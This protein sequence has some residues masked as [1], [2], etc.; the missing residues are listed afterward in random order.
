MLFIILARLKRTGRFITLFGR[1][2]GCI[3]ALGR[4]A[5]GPSIG[6]SVVTGLVFIGP[7]TSWGPS[8][9]KG[10]VVAGSIMLP[11]ASVSILSKAGGSRVLPAV[12][13]GGTVGAG[14]LGRGPPGSLWLSGVSGT[15]DEGVLCVF[16]RLS[17]LVMGGS[18]ELGMVPNCPSSFC[19]TIG[20]GVEIPC[21]SC[22]GFS[23]AFVNVN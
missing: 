15:L 13:G 2:L 7:E 19:A 21:P 12:C 16:T 4:D 18:L 6:T 5:L 10:M 1:E 23:T 20:A 22:D 11:W 9:A 14:G 17:P 3:W 8:T